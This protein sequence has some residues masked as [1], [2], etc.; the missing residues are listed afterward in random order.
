MPFDELFAISEP[1]RPAP[2]RARVFQSV[3]CSRCGEA[4]REDMV[5]LSGGKPVCLDCLDAYPRTLP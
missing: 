3:A 1:R 2:E 5:R 4:A